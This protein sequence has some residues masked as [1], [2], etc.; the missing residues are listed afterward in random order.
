MRQSP[1]TSQ[2]GLVSLTNRRFWKCWFEDVNE[3]DQ[4][5]VNVE[6]IGVKEPRPP[7]VSYFRNT[8]HE[9]LSVSDLFGSLHR[10]LFPLHRDSFCSFILANM[11][12]HVYQNDPDIITRKYISWMIVQ[13]PGLSS[14]SRPQE[15][16]RPDRTGTDRH[17]QRQRAPRGRT[18]LAGGRDRSHVRNRLDRLVPPG[19]TSQSVLRNKRLSLSSGTGPRIR[20]LTNLHHLAHLL[21]PTWGGQL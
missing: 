5:R 3:A 18:G 1:S 12:C 6:G 13:H 15:A 9:F 10:F 4:I 8:T 2:W 14:I 7:P 19:Q 11:S 17:W 16:W 20:G 21:D